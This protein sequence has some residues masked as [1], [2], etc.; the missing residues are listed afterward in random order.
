MDI[1]AHLSATNERFKSLSREEKE[2]AFREANTKNTTVLDVSSTC[3]VLEQ[4]V[5]PRKVRM[6]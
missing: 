3:L 1:F 2:A 5:I 6:E 4:R